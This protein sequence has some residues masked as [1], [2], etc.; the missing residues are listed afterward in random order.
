MC[1]RSVFSEAEKRR[2]KKTGET[3]LVEKP[4]SIYIVCTP[5]WEIGCTPK[6]GPN[7]NPTRFGLGGSQINK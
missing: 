2:E 4:K 1:V 3:D 7:S 6:K 5:F